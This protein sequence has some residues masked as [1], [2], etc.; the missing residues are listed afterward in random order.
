MPVAI[1]VTVIPSER[2]L[3]L[4]PAALHAAVPDMVC[5]PASHAVANS[6]RSFT[7]LG[8]DAGVHSVI[9]GLEAA[10]GSAV[11]SPFKHHGGGSSAPDQSQ[12]QQQQQQWL[13]L[14]VDSAFDGTVA[15]ASCSLLSS[16]AATL[17]L[18]KLLLEDPALSG[19]VRAVAADWKLAAKGP[20]VTV[21]VRSPAIEVL[22]PTQGV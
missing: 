13:F 11:P 7:W 14:A 2:L 5:I 21:H 6:A 9:Q 12:P 10:Q 3:S 16:S 8:T 4:A 20:A 17:K 18:R 22:E 1:V 15:G 19:A